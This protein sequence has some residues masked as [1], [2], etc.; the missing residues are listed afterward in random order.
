MAS[1][2]SATAP[3]SASA[4]ASAV[5]SSS[6]AITATVP[7]SVVERRA[8]AAALATSSAR[9]TFSTSGNTPVLRTGRAGSTPGAA[10][11][12]NRF[13]TSMISDGVR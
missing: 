10:A 4:P 2:A 6:G 5:C 7:P 11:G 3:R 13:A 12:S 1:T 9:P 8:A